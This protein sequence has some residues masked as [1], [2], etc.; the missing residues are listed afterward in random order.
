[1]AVGAVSV[2]ALTMVFSRPDEVVQF[3]SE[4]TAIVAVAA[5]ITVTAGAVLGGVTAALRRG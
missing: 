2:V 5:M 3:A 4:H 1:M